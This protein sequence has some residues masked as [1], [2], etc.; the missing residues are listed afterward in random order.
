MNDKSVTLPCDVESNYIR[1]LETEKAELLELMISKDGEIASLEYKLE[2]SDKW[3]EIYG[4]ASE[5]R[6]DTI[7]NLQMRLDQMTGAYEIYRESAKDLKIA[8][9]ALQEFADPT[10]EFYV[11]HYKEVAGQKVGIIKSI[12]QLSKHAEDALRKIGVL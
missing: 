6:L 11:D 9:K 2:E 8:T 3:K 5:N 4:L 12:I 10:Q 7:R 1:N